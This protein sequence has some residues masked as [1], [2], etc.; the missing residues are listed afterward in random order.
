MSMFLLAISYLTTSNLPWF[1][2]LTFQ[3]LMWYCSLQ[4]W[5]LFS[6][7]G[8]SK[9]GRCLRFGAALFL[10]LFLCASPVSMLD[11]H[12]SGGLIFQCHIFLPF[13]TAHGLL[14]ARI[15][16][17][18]PI[19]FSSGPCFVIASLSHASP[20]TDKAVIHVIILVNFLWLWF[21]FWSLWDCSS[22]FSLPYDGWG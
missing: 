14:E 12:W 11:T 6:P 3:V 9:T 5:T 13:H 8:T 20:F 16:E 18:F 1:M 17:G 4:H 19:L 22:C 7:P 21:S 10:E 15:L 2:D